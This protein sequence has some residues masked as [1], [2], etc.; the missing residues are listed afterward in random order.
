MSESIQHLSLVKN[1]VDHIER[2]FADLRTLVVFADLQNGL[3][4]DKPFR[5]SGFAPDIY[6]TDVPTTVTVV[7]EAKTAQDISTGH[8]MAQVSAFL[9]FLHFEKRGV[10]FMNVPLH[11]VPDARALVKAA[12]KS[13]NLGIINVE[14]NILGDAKVLDPTC[15]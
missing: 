5:I 10:F 13:L 9:E 4:D 15:R 1:L 14:V 11:A 8:S 3:G 2:E 12:K 7:G 6:A